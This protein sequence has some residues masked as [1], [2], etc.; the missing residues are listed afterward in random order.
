VARSLLKLFAT[1][2][3]L[4]VDNLPVRIYSERVIVNQNKM[5]MKAK[6]ESNPQSWLPV[7]QPVF[8]PPTV[9][10]PS[11][12]DDNG[13]RKRHYNGT[14]VEHLGHS[15]VAVRFDDYPNVTDY[16]GREAAKFVKMF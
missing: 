15:G 6:Q 3:N 14:V 5:T 12:F 7:G 9:Y 16:T 13:G 2:C 8:I 10:A 4:S 1:K 11:T